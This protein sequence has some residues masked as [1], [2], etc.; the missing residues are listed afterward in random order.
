M[1][2]SIRASLGE[3]D[4]PGLSPSLFLGYHTLSRSSF[5]PNYGFRGPLL[6]IISDVQCNPFFPDVL[7]LS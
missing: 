3:F 2:V 4:G 6:P 7:S 5:P 1:G